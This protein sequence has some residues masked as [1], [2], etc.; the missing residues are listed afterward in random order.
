MFQSVVQELHANVIL[1]N[2]IK[3]L[4]ECATEQMHSRSFVSD[5]Q[6]P[7]TLCRIY[8]YIY[9]VTLHIYTVV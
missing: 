6:D 4:N 9:T 1:V 7:V 2:R 5:V 3:V 8:I